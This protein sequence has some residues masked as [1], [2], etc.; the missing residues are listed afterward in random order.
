MDK[1]TCCHTGTEGSDQIYCLFCQ[2]L[3]VELSVCTCGMYF[4][5][6]LTRGQPIFTPTPYI[7]WKHGHWNASFKL[8]VGLDQDLNPKFPSKQMPLALG[9]V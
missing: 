3:V 8:L 4:H 1:Y 5:S 9:V 7:I 2:N 6:I